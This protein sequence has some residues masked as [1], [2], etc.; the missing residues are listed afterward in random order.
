MCLCSACFPQPLSLSPVSRGHELCPGQLCG[1]FNSS[2]L[3]FRLICGLM[4]L[5]QGVTRELSHRSQSVTVTRWMSP[6]TACS[7][8][9]NV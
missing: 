5:L 9:V 1:S 3:K 6:I 7:S 2:W 8:A 4:K